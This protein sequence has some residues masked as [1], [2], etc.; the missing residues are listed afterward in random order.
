MILI[1][2]TAK[3]DG[4]PPPS[5]VSNMLH[6]KKERKRLSVS[7]FRDYCLS[8]K[9]S[10]YNQIWIYCY[11][12]L[13]LYHPPL[14]IYIYI[15]I[16]LCILLH[17]RIGPLVY[18]SSA[19]MHDSTFTSGQQRYKTRGMIKQDPRTQQSNPFGWPIY[20]RSRHITL[21]AQVRRFGES[22]SLAN[23]TNN[24]NAGTNQ[25]TQFHNTENVY[26][27]KNAEYLWYSYISVL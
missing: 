14:C 21:A 12:S 5:P 22:L 17:S 4:G 11:L 20:A 25:I 26:T 1:L 19:T 7:D 13:Y 2:E 18:N 10:S 8:T 27:S 6:F 9:Q 16:L 23:L 3:H 24:F 15:Y